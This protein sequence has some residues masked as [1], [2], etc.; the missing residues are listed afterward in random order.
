MN[1]DDDVY[2]QYALARYTAAGKLDTSFDGDG[3]VITTMVFRVDPLLHRRRFARKDPRRRR[4]ARRTACRASWWS[5][6][7][8]TAEPTARSCTA[9]C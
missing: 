2:E 9:R 7:T 3:K 1:I 5:G 8:V 6:S 4:H